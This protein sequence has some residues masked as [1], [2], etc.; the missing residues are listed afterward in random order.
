MGFRGGRRV[1]VESEGIE[2]VPGKIDIPLKR[3]DR[4]EVVAEWTR[5]KASL[6]ETDHVDFAQECGCA[7]GVDVTAGS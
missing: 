6:S 4:A 5:K 7:N 1:E 2:V 3:S